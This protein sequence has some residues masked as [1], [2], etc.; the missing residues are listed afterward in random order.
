GTYRLRFIAPT[1]KQIEQDDNGIVTITSRHKSGR[2]IISPKNTQGL[3]AVEISK[4]GQEPI[5]GAWRSTVPGK[6]EPAYSIDY[7]FSGENLNS[8]MTIKMELANKN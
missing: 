6:I 1:D 2:I 4:A 5:S 8:E 7:L 3:K